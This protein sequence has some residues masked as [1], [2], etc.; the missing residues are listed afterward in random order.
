MRRRLLTIGACAVLLGTLAA[1]TPATV[2]YIAIQRNEDGTFTGVVAMCDGALS[3]VAVSRF[4]ESAVADSSSLPTPG[5]DMLWEVD[6]AVRGVGEIPLPGM[7]TYMVSGPFHLFGAGELRRGIVSSSRDGRVDGPENFTPEDVAALSAGQ[8]LA[9]NPDTP[10]N[11][12]AISRSEFV[13]QA[14]D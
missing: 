9:P 3:L 4:S 1:C 6:P 11:P 2:G 12:L 7:E 5:S 8:V 10:I 14:C 13:E